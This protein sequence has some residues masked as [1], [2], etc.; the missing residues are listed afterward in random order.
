MKKYKVE[1]TQSEK[2]IVDVYAKDEAEA[3]DKAS[4]LFNLGYSET[5]GDIELDTTIY[6]VTDTDDPFNPL[7]DEIEC[8]IVE[9]KENVKIDG[10]ERYI[11]GHAVC[12]K[13]AYEIDK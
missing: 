12:T 3:K 4:E 5:S 7:N 9:C 10:K 13:H 6:D 2:F 8:S 11:N 1:F